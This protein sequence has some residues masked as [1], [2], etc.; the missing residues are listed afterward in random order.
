MLSIIVASLFSVILIYS[1]ELEGVLSITVASLFSV[2]L[3]YNIELEGVLSIIVASLFSVKGDC[4][5]RVYY[6]AIIPI[7]RYLIHNV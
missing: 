7:Y 3:I 5:I 6:K 1:I 2:I 4:F